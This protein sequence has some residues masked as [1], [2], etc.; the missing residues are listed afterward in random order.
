MYSIHVFHMGYRTITGFN[1]DINKAV[2][3]KSKEIAEQEKKS[4]EDKYPN[5]KVELIKG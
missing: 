2:F 1:S 4:W 5:W 3:F